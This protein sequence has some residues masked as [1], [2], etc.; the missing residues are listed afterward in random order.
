MWHCGCESDWES[1]GCGFDP[2]PRSVG[3]GPDVA[4]SCGVGRRCS[5]DL[6][7][8]WCRLAAVAPIG[9][10]ACEPPYAMGMDLKRKTKN[11]KQKTK[12]LWE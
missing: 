6:M 5:L 3:W 9:P 8:L 12:N 1:I 4:V 11:K 7:W 10:L 2:W